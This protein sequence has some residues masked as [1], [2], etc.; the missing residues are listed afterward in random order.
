MVLDLPPVDLAAPAIIQRAEP[1]ELD[2]HR[3][4]SPLGLPRHVR[5]AI[6]AEFKRLEGSGP[7]IYRPAFADLAR[8]GKDPAL[9]HILCP[10]IGWNTTGPLTLTYI[11][12]ATN[13]T[14]QTTYNFGDF[15][16]PRAGL[17]IVAAVLR[18]GSNAR[19]VSSVSIGGT[20]GSIH[21][22]NA[23]DQQKRATASRVVSA[24]NNNV[25]VTLSG[26]NGSNAIAAVGVW[27][28]ENYSSATPVGSS[29]DLANSAITSIDAVF[30]YSAG[31]VGVYG[32]YHNNNSATGWSTANDQY[33]AIVNDSGGNAR[34]FSFA[35]KTT[36]SAI[37]PHTET[38]SWTSS[39][40]MITG[41]S[42]L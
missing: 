2:L 22:T 16:I 14:D 40:G 8:Y 24:G 25:T 1:W 17:V 6:V 39:S 5:R 37:T 7:R 26:S 36:V 41:G 27:L 32:H 21:D 30:N 28:L 38:A 11:S 29:G 35:D 10:P 23:S 33:D 31:G 34:R 42:W 4:L 15:S 19:T 9:A 3:K 12:Q 18:S 20:N 13:S